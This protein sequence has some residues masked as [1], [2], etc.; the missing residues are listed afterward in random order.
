MQG[1]CGRRKHAGA[2]RMQVRAWVWVLR[3]RGVG[4]VDS[5]SAAVARRGR[6]GGSRREGAGEGPR[7]RPAT[8]AVTHRR[9]SDSTRSAH[10]WLV[11]GLGL[12][13]LIVRIGLQACIATTRPNHWTW[14]TWGQS[15][16][17]TGCACSA[18]LSEQGCARPKPVEGAAGQR[19]GV[20][21]GL[22]CQVRPNG[23]EVH[24]AALWHERKRAGQTRV[25][26]SIETVACSMSPTDSAMCATRGRVGLHP[27][28]L[29]SGTAR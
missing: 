19:I 14:S 8:K 9:S 26:A 10:T 25:A 6:R 1:G 18:H 29:V 2:K 20:R 13:D 17:R 15:D 16:C 22:T 5:M 7:P 12:G 11:F 27:N 21:F 4:P 24:T 3:A 28:H 23:S